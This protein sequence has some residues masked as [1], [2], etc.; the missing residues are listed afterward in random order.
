MV[1]EPQYEGYDNLSKVHNWSL[2]T[3]FTRWE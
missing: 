2:I 3:M 1:G